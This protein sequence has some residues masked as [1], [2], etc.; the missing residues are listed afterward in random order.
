M[1]NVLVLGIGNRLM[2]DDGLGVRIVEILQNDTGISGIRYVIGE[3][4]IDYSLNEMDGAEFLIIVDAVLTGKSAGELS[5]FSLEKYNRLNLG[6]SAH[7][8]H[9]LH[10]I[11]HIYPDLH[12]NIIGIEVDRI[13]FG[14]E[15]SQVI[16]EKF[17]EITR[18]VRAV[19]IDILLKQHFHEN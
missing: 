6:I 2:M 13:D 10:M 15:L 8:L 3:T 12:V 4:D 14:L 16:Q 7:N 1:N 5:V 19:I 18:K 11:P 17:S 9:L